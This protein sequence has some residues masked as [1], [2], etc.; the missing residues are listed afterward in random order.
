MIFAELNLMIYREFERVID[1]IM[2]TFVMNFPLNI[3][4]TYQYLVVR[5]LLH[6]ID[7]SSL[8]KGMSAVCSESCIGHSSIGESCCL[9]KSKVFLISLQLA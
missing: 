7:S 1:I 6:L 2:I 9:M 8:M 3:L 5:K 4:I